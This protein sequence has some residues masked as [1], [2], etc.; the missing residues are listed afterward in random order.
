MAERPNQSIHTF[1][2]DEC[3]KKV[4]TKN[5][6]LFEKR[7]KFVSS[8]C[9]EILKAPNAIGSVIPTDRSATAKLIRRGEVRLSLLRCFQNTN[10]VKMLPTMTSKDSSIAINKATIM[11]VL[12]MIVIL[13]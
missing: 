4:L 2:R 13:N 12:Y 11:A 1:Q 3:E 5:Q 6:K 10:M 9:P 7:S 8:K